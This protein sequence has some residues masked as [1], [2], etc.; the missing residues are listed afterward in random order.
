MRLR[1][2]LFVA[3]VLVSS[4]PV[5]ILAVWEQRESLN[6]EIRAVSEKHLLVAKNLTAALDRYVKD[7]EITFAT[8]SK[9]LRDIDHPHDHKQLLSALGFRHVSTVDSNGYIQRLQCALNCPTAN[10]FSPTVFKALAVERQMALDNPGKLF[11]SNLVKNPKETPSI[12]L[13]RSDQKD[14][15]TIGELSTQYPQKIQKT[16]S[17]GRGGHAA[18]VDKKGQ[19]IAHPLPEWVE[20]MRDLSKLSIVQKMMNGGSG[21]T[22]FYSPAVKAEMVAG[23]NVVA[24][25]GWGVMVP[26]PFQE[27]ID[28]SSELRLA[29][30]GITLFGIL[31]AALISWWL[32]G[33]LAEPLRKMAT[34]A[35]K[36]SEGDLSVR[37]TSAPRLPLRETSELAQALNSMLEHLHASN[38]EILEASEQARVANLAKSEFLSAMSHELRTPLTSIKGALALMNSSVSGQIPDQKKELFE[39]SLRNC[40]AMML[41][42]NELL[43]YEKVISGA[44]VIE[45]HPHDLTA[46]TSQVVRDNQGYASTQSVTFD[47]IDP[48]C[49]I[50]ARV[51]EHRFEQVL[52]NL[53]S[54]AA[55]FSDPGSDV[56]ISV[57]SDNGRVVVSVEDHG[58]GISEEFRTKIFE[59]F[60]QI[61]SSAT[62]SHAG[63]GLGLA[64]SKS[65][66]EGM[67]GTLTFESEEGVGSTFYVSFPKIDFPESGSA[68]LA[69]GTA[70]DTL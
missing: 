48:E 37:V 23:Y 27:L 54:N 9:F 4:I 3:L 56:K 40:D 18:I 8:V 15:L 53:L 36:V 19:L 21:V 61:D 14:Q 24:A 20:Q 5:I 28:K 44:L 65:L 62:R 58:E 30:L 39:I 7:V 13:I 68:E 70:S 12:Y 64:I 67:G 50:F 47:F 63:T 10:R 66:T 52:R 11:I 16:I 33:L 32:S 55:K 34:T 35:I 29:V 25:T 31:I 49:P 26:Q 42:V 69:S 6:Q 2:I 57:C 59:Q 17:F 45:T 22:Q 41:L 46:L 38:K 1:S 43:D 60:T 51:Q